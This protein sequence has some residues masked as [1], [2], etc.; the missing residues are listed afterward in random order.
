M[1]IHKATLAPVYLEGYRT[2][3]IFFQAT[4]GS[5][6]AVV[7][8]AVHTRDGELTVPRPGDSPGARDGVHISGVQLRN[9]RQNTFLIKTS[10]PECGEL[11]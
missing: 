4:T 8:M 7:A 10:Y 5:L 1:R 11:E 6:A 3:S 2:G 9:L